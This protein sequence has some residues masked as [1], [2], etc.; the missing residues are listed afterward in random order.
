MKAYYIIRHGVRIG[1]IQETWTIE[2][3]YLILCGVDSYG[4][5]WDERRI[6]SERVW[7]SRVQRGTKTYISLSTG[8]HPQYF[9]EPCHDL[10]R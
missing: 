6:M 3:M 7:E 1:V 5:F 2:R 9:L 8:D 10:P 4:T